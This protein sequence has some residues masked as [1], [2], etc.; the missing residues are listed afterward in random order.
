MKTLRPIEV[1]IQAMNST[2]SYSA[3][4]LSEFVPLSVGRISKCLSR[5]H[6]FGFVEE[7][8]DS[9]FKRD[10]RWKAKQKDLFR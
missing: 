8:S 10:K 4:E 5:L 7:T 6:S 1:V 9:R 2:Y 3:E